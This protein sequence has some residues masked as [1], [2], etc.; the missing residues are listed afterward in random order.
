MIREHTRM[1]IDMLKGSKL[2][3]ALTILG[4]VIGV[5]SVVIVITLG[6][7]VK[8]QIASE[9]EAFGANLIQITPGKSVERDDKG[10]ITSFNFASSFGISTL[11]ES[12]VEKL[13]Q[14]PSVEAVAPF[15]P[16][17][18]IVG[19][20]GRELK[21]AIIAA[22][23]SE[24]PKAL[25]QEVKIGNFF[26]EEQTGNVVVLGPGAAKQLFEGPATVGGAIEIRGEKF[27]VTG[28]MSEMDSIFA[29]LG[30]NLDNAVF[31]PLEIGKRFNQGSTQLIEI[32][33][34][35]KE[36]S[37]VNAAIDRFRALLKENHNGAED[38]TILK[39][40][41]ILTIVDQ[42]LG[43]VT[44][45]V[46]AIAAISLVVGGI[47]IM[48]I[49]LVSVTERTREIGLRKA[50]GATNRQIKTQFL[51]ESIILSLLGGLIGVGFAFFV[52][53]MVTI[54]TDI[55]G[56]FEIQTIILGAGVSSVV[57]VIFGLWPAVNAA[58]KDP[59]VSLRYE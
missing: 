55:N 59:V 58:R 47:G 7:G 51:I 28:I 24:Y 33:I 39:Q 50:V 14:D 48:N 32:D 41:E 1:A 34:Q 19:K 21:N 42:I 16:I 10:E 18:G 17:T 46:A 29:E 27:I 22:T 6:R 20:D 9:V 8:N 35:L 13:R 56:S 11:T 44:T 12:D 23:N 52:V 25:N 49:M 15:M 31:I 4:I 37:D 3:S 5:A 40:E 54:F 36:G 38:F 53:W 43:I 30:P 26:N 57:G 2:R 45:F